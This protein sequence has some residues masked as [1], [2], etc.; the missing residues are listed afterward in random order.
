MA[1]RCVCVHVCVEA[2]DLGYALNPVYTQEVVSQ[3]SDVYF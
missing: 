3:S 1:F 2:E